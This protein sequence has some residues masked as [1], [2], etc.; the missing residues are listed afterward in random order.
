M[1]VPC[2]D[3]CNKPVPTIISLEYKA[4]VYISTTNKTDRHDITALL[5]TVAL[6]TISIAL[7]PTN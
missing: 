5:L 1:T 6:N 4:G 7:T 3:I 2:N